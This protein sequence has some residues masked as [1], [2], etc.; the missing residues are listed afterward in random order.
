MSKYHFLLTF[1]RIV[2]LTPHQFLVDLRMRRAAT[3]LCTAQTPISAIAFDAGFGDLSTR[4]GRFRDVFG[5]S[6]G[7]L[8]RSSR[9]A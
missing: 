2:G 3:V 6:P 1:R 5:A 7:G 8:R 4:N 9:G